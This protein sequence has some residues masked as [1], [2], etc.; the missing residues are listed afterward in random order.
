V[1]VDLVVI[2]PWANQAVLEHQ[3]KV[4][5]AAV[6]MDL[7]Q[8][9]IRPQVIVAVAVAVVALV[10]AAPVV[11]QPQDL[12]LAAAADYY[13]HI[14]I[15]HTLEAE[16]GAALDLRSSQQAHHRAAAVAP[17]VAAVELLIHLLYRL[18]Q[19]QQIL[20]AEEEAGMATIR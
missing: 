16:E 2:V 19:E 9:Q 13:I 8:E 20:V 17:V 6:A 7:L 3:A 12:V 10:L 11:V 18:W 15:L 1:A 14:P 4:T 5:Q